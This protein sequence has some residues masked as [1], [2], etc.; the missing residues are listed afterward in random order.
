[1]R[2]GT[3]GKV[4]AAEVLSAAM[5]RL[6]LPLRF[7]GKV[8]AVMPN[9]RVLKALG[10]RILPGK[11]PLLANQPEV[12]TRR[13]RYLRMRQS[14]GRGLVAVWVGEKRVR[15]AALPTGAGGIKAGSSRSRTG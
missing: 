8:S 14:V 5:E 4:K 11:S 12:G 13:G 10:G 3:S 15:S 9:G 7:T 2:R 6:L 1:M